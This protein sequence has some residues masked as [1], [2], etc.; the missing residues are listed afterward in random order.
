MEYTTLYA[1]MVIGFRHRR[2]T[3]PESGHDY[4]G[5]QY[6][7]TTIM[8]TLMMPLLMLEVRGLLRDYTLWCSLWCSLWMKTTIQP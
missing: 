4:D 2:M 6:I 1:A 3:V 5:Y 7:I 8:V